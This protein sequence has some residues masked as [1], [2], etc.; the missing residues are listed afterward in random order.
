VAPELDE[1]VLARLRKRVELKDAQ[2]LCDMALYYGQGRYG[3]PMNQAKCID[4]MRESAGLGYPNAQ[5]HLGQFH[6]NGAM[7][8]E[9]NEE[10]A[11]KYYKKAAE[12]GH[13]FARHNLAC[14]AGRDGD[15]VVAMTHLRLSASGGYRKSMDNLIILC[16]EGGFLRHGDLA[17]TLQVFYLAR[18]ELKSN[19]RDQYIMHLKKTGEYSEYMD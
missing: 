5:Y 13:V 4:L 9:Q 19:D 16:F 2:A 12:D 15:Y 3:L 6:D 8:L 11:L 10:E 18:A 17:E 1:E 14:N 7:G